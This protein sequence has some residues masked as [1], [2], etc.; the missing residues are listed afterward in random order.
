MR[1]KKSNIICSVKVSGLKFGSLPIA[2][3]LQPNFYKLSCAEQRITKLDWKSTMY[4]I[5]EYLWIFTSILLCLIFSRFLI[6]FIY[7][8]NIG[9]WQVLFITC[10]QLGK[11]YSA[12]S[13]FKSRVFTAAVLVNFG[14]IVFKRLPKGYSSWS[15]KINTLCHLDLFLLIWGYVFT[16]Q[17]PS[18]KNYI[19]H[20]QRHFLKCFMTVLNEFF[21]NLLK[22][23]LFLWSLI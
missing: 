17:V 11:S 2:D 6:L 20:W 3:Q 21:K 22:H 14:N 4:S 10:E 8:I 18:S 23:H 12:T 5:I 9:Y 15:K 7:I 19:T 16:I 13:T 1:S